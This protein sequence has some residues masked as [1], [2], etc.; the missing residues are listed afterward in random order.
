[1]HSPAT[2]HAR[3]PRPIAGVPAARP[4]AHVA[5]GL[6]LA[7]VLAPL[8]ALGAACGARPPPEAPGAASAPP[9]A[10]GEAPAAAQAPPAPRVE[11]G[12]KDLLFS[13]VDARGEVRAVSS[14]DEV[15]VSVRERVIVTDLS[16]TPEQRMAHR[17][18]WFVDLRT[19][20]PDGTYPVTVVSRY[21]AAK[22][23]GIEVGL[24]PVAEGA[25]IVYSAEWCGFCKKAK[26]WLGEKGV[27]FVE[28]DVERQRGASRE[29]ADKL[30]KA[31]IR[32]GGVPVIDWGGELIM[33]FDV[34]RM[35]ALL[36][37]RP[38]GGDAP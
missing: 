38:A 22:G 21:N 17:Y 11:A 23:E 31:G 34:A 1:M 20:R 8:F 19:P 36:A 12:R 33:G 6:A 28:R 14:I 9:G 18:A 24:P 3:V 5:L 35:G 13:F 7:S 10:G 25:V 27:P 16:L 32:G 29:L 26:K 37:S 15:P 4:V 2:L 30:E